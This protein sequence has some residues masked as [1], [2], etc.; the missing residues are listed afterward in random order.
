MSTNLDVTD[1]DCINLSELEIKSDFRFQKSDL[2]ET[3]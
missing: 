3:A 2:R 1:R